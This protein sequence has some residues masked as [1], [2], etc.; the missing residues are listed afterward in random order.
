MRLPF[1]SARPDPTTPV[2][3]LGRRGVLGLLPAAVTG[4]LLAVPGAPALAAVPRFQRPLRGRIHVTSEFNPRRRNPVTH[5]VTA[6]EGT[7]LRA[8]SGTRVYAALRGTV[9]HVGWDPSEHA[10]AGNQITIDHHNGYQT[11]YS[12]LRAQRWTV[13]VGQKV[14][15]GQFLGLSGATG[16]ATGPHLHFGVM[17]RGRWINPRSVLRL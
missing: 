7:D 1:R 10:K 11:R 9:V 14:S 5:V 16:R 2:P 17:R 4:V 3:R 15:T 12:H 6:H 13:R 8:P